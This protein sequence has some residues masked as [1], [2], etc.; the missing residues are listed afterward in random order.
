MTNRL[1][2]L[3]LLLY[4]ALLY[5]LS[6][7]HQLPS[8]QLFANEDKLEHFL[9]Y[10][11]LAILAW[12]A[13]SPRISRRL[14][15]LLLSVG[16][17]ALYGAGDEWHQSFVPGRQAGADDWLADCLGACAAALVAY[18]RAPADSPQHRV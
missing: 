10:A 7:Q 2:D 5:W 17:C 8:P 16:F 3:L 14:P 9:A 15:L 13:F 11:L 18:G 4:C 1:N 6:D 12:R